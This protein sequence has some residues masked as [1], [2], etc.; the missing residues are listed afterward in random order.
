M[1]SQ[2]FYR[3]GRDNALMLQRVQADWRPT[4]AAFK[5]AEPEINDGID[6]Y[7]C[8]HS[9]AAVFHMMRVAELGLRALARERQISW[10]KKPIEWAEWQELIGH[11]DSS[12][13]SAA[14][15]LPKGLERDAALSFYS[16]AAG[17][18]HALKDKYRNLVMRFRA[19]YG[20][21]EAAQAINQVKDFMNGLS[22][23]VSEKTRR[24]IRKWP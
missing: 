17:Q 1:N 14:M 12:G 20:E 21:L 8:G 2:C 22:L 13:R 15:L 11:I 23:R 18:F 9:T 10:P 6:C 19:S 16:G 3:Y 24:P 5:S 4:L 7:A